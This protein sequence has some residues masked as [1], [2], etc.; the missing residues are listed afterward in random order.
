MKTI[1]KM[2]GEYWYVNKTPRWMRI[3]KYFVWFGGWTKPVWDN[4]GGYTEKFKFTITYTHSG[5]TRL[6]DPYPLTIKFFGRDITFFGTWCQIKMK[7]GWLVIIRQHSRKCCY[8]SL[9]GTP[10]GAT[11]W[12][13]G[14]PKSV[15]REI[16]TP[17]YILKM[18]AKKRQRKEVVR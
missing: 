5:K 15:V 9:D 3:L 7:G 18:N 14:A 1:Q 10:E 8:F 11:K 13:W 17:D 4:E 6:K 2:D 16:Q 12:F